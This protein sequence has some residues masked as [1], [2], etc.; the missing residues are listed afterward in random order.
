VLLFFYLVTVGFAL[1]WL[2]VYCVATCP[3]QEP[4]S[5]VDLPSGGNVTILGLEYEEWFWER[6]FHV[7]YVTST[8]GRYDSVRDEVSDLLVVLESNEVI[9]QE[10]N[11]LYFGVWYTHMRFDGW[12]GFTSV[13]SCCSSNGVIYKRDESNAWV[14]YGN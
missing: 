13:F 1:L 3:S 12:Y 5:Q 4:I 8:D 6:S 10:A 2:Y 14:G 11:R 7:I 9:P